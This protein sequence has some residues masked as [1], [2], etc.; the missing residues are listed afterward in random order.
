MLISA[1]YVHEMNVICVHGG[2]LKRVHLN[3]SE[4]QELAVTD[5]CGTKKETCTCR[6]TAMK[7]RGQQASMFLEY[8][9]V[10]ECL[11]DEKNETAKV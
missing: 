7:N 8:V 5:V 2:L 4:C 1:S 11:W 6:Q 10:N 3:R 9:H